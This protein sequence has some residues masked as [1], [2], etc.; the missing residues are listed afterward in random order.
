MAELDSSDRLSVFQ[1]Q[2]IATDEDPVL[3]E[4][5]AK[6]AELA[7]APLAAVTLVMGAIQYFRAGHNLPPDLAHSRA[8]SRED[9]WCQFVVKG[10]APFKVESASTDERVPQRVV[11]TYGVQ[12]YLGVPVTIEGQQAGS[13]CV[14]DVQPREF[15]E[16]LQER[17]EGLA[18]RATERL[19]T[20]AQESRAKRAEARAEQALTRAKTLDFQARLLE[21]A[22]SEIGPL[23]RIARALSRSE[24]A[25]EDA[26][27]GASM[28]TEAGP[29][30]ELLI[31][32]TQ[33]LRA[34]STQLV[35]LLEAK[36]PSG[37]DSTR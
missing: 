9:S 13:L 26:A 36:D 6:A 10:E 35:E 32:E 25:P 7:S 5:V 31:E 12:S 21:R 15:D 2:V 22:M 18:A 30:F 11:E 14:F 37:P 24:L 1:G 34:T 20:L 33:G 16:Q 8:T 4:L 28:L 19:N 29:M 23:V 27:R 17:L 3:Q